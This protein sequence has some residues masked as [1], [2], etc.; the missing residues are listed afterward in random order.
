MTLPRHI[1]TSS[2]SIHKRRPAV[3]IGLILLC[4]F[5]ELDPLA[6]DGGVTEAQSSS[7]DGG[8]TEAQSS[9]STEAA[10]NIV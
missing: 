9:S 4:E 3:L 1:R 8:V 2:G 10:D 6:S 5:A 7:S